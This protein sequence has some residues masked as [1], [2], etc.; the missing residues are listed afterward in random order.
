MYH[1]YEIVPFEN[2]PSKISYLIWNAENETIELSI[3]KLYTGIV[4]Q[5]CGA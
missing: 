4:Y 3:P 1:Q 2:I 5:T